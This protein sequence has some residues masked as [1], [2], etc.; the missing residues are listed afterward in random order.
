MS[1]KFAN[2]ISGRQ[3]RKEALLLLLDSKQFKG[4]WAGY[5]GYITHATNFNKCWQLSGMLGL[6]N[7]L[8]PKQVDWVHDLKQSLLKSHFVSR[9]VTRIAW[10]QT[11]DDCTE[12]VER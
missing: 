5:T 11:K 4:R 8:R 1:K 9:Q 10:A 7:V 3:P 2:Q 6:F 12:R